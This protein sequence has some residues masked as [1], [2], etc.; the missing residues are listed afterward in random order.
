MTTALN[1]NQDNQP[2]LDMDKVRQALERIKKA[3]RTSP[4]VPDMK[5]VM[6]VGGLLVTKGKWQDP[7]HAPTEPP[8]DSPNRT[9]TRQVHSGCKGFDHPDFHP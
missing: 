5:K 3:P 7:E 6:V 1:E 8:V 9:H 4:R 2:P